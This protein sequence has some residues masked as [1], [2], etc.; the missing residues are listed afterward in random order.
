M[1][2]KF[3]LVAARTIPGHHAAWDLL[4]GGYDLTAQEPRHPG[5]RRYEMGPGPCGRPSAATPRTSPLPRESTSGRRRSPTTSTCHD[6]TNASTRLARRYCPVIVA[7]QTGY[8]WSLMEVEY[9]TDIVFRNQ[10]DL[11]PIDENG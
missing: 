8:H 1:A 9:S 6:C 5:L 2:G 4:R 3:N 10:T 7:V 11:A